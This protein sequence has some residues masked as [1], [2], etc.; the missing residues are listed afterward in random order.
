M[1]PSLFL[2]PP[3]TSSGVTSSGGVDP[4]DICSPLRS[5]GIAGTLII[6]LLGS[7]VR[8]VCPDELDRSSCW[9]GEENVE[10]D[11]VAGVVWGEEMDGD[12]LVGVGSMLS[13]VV[14]ADGGGTAM[15]DEPDV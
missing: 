4:N 7:W 5:L 6:L 14:G 11:R 10:V 9:E 8:T 1:L 2:P 15:M 13:W 3:L 12:E